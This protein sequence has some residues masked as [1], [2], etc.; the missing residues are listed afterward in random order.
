MSRA[1]VNQNSVHARLDECVKAL[2]CMGPDMPLLWLALRVQLFAFPLLIGGWDQPC[3]HR[4][5]PRDIKREAKPSLALSFGGGPLWRLGSVLSCL[6]LIKVLSAC[7]VTELYLVCCL[8]SLLQDQS[9]EILPAWAVISPP[10]QI[11]VMMR[12]ELWERNKQY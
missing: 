3:F 5:E 12:L 2:F 10:F 8:K 1:T 4:A 6:F 11:F 7:A 9:H